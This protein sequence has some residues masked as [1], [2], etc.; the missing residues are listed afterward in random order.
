MTDQSVDVNSISDPIQLKVLAF[1]LE[2]GIE[3]LQASYRLV[4]ERLA[5]VESG[6]AEVEAPEGDAPDEGA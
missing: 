1:D 6:G 4:R 2:R 5:F 3:R